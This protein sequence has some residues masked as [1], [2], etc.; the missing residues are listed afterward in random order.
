MRAKGFLKGMELLGRAQA[1]NCCDCPPISLD[2]KQ[3]TASNGNAVE[4]NRTSATD[5]VFASD[6]SSGELQLLPQSVDQ[7]GA[8]INKKGMLNA[9]N[10]QSNRLSS[11]GLGDFARF[12]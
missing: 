11:H 4:E 12:A 3:Q 10:C 2:S 6:V 8:N 9:I 1:F 7:R 5:P